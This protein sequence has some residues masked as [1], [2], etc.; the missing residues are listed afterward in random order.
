MESHSYFVP[1][2]VNVVEEMRQQNGNIDGAAL[3]D[4]FGDND[5]PTPESIWSF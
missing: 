4:G 3:D 1:Q 5:R 2:G